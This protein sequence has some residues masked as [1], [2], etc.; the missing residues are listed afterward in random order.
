M[1]AKIS[2]QS[3]AVLI[4]LD[5]NGKTT[6]HANLPINLDCVLHIVTIEPETD[7]FSAA[8]K[9]AILFTLVGLQSNYIDKHLQ[10]SGSNVWLFDTADERDHEYQNL[11]TKLQ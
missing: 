4:L 8:S 6:T 10:I 11:L 2:K 9:Y 1:F 5:D 7:G 3:N